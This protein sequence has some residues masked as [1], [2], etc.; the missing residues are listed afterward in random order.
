MTDTPEW[1]AWHG[2]FDR[3]YRASYVH[4]HNYGGRGISVCQRWHG[5]F[6]NFFADMGQRPGPKYSLDRIDTN[7]N[8]EPDN[9]RW[10]TATQQN[11]NQRRTVM[12]TY[13]GVT[14]P[15]VEWAIEV[16]IHSETIRRRVLKYGWTTERALTTPSL[17][18]RT[19]AHD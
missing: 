15:L 13:N 19:N 14:L 4:Y 10:A 9:C 5:S 3:C 17:I 11:L 6:E 16:G 8:Y 18:N 7:G 1:R 2:M 12:L